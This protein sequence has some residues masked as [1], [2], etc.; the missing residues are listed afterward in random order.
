MLLE[1]VIGVLK[2]EIFHLGSSTFTIGSL[3][4]L[5]G[6]LTALFLVTSMLK[7]LLV[8]RVFPRYN[9]DNGT[10]ISIA[11]IIRYAIV[12][13]G[14]MIILRT[15]GIDVSSFGILFGA[16]GIGIGFGLQGI[17]N[18]FISGIIILFERPVKV[19]DRIEVDGHAGNIV[20]ISARATTIIT[21]DN[22][23]IILPNSDL[24]NSKVINW[25]L[26]DKI[27]RFNFPV[28]VS[29]KENPQTV[30]DILLEVVNEC[31]GVLKDPPADVLFEEFGDS[32]LNFNLRVWT[33][34]YSDKPKV[35]KS[36]LYY[37]VFRKFSELNIEI[38]FP[39]RDLHII[40]GGEK[41]EVIKA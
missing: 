12:I 33:T 5:I 17:S 15:S 25:S 14:L 40:S 38:P 9:L 23:A 34:E 4:A 32:S 22:I 29:Y 37:S 13:V 1:D 28:A 18:N 21:N 31:D 35:L 10:A 7:K 19:G 36:I 30:K 26:N 20:K 8:K 39:Q 11:T 16:V 41:S 3:L 24:V 6:S 2:R 27:V